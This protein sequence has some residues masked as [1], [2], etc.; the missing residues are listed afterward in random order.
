MI[1]PTA[2]SHEIDETSPLFPYSK[3]LSK[4]PGCIFVQSY[5]SDDFL[6]CASH[7][8]SIFFGPDIVQGYNFADVTVVA[9][10][11]AYE[12]GMN[13]AVIDFTSFNEITPSRLF[14]QSMV[15]EAQT[16]TDL[17]NLPL[18]GG[19]QDVAAAFYDEHVQGASVFGGTHDITRAS[20]DEHILH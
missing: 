13:H 14:S 1:M 4:L 12:R 9:P 10:Q 16:S 6:N 15:L 19:T 3:D 5:G 18:L 17:T 20:D 7:G 2:L 8:M 11:E